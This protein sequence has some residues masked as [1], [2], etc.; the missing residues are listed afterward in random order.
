MDKKPSRKVRVGRVVSSATEKTAVVIVEEL[1]R[2]P[3]YGKTVKKSTRLHAHDEKNE[4]SVGDLVRI[5]ETRPISRMKRWKLV[6][7]VEKAR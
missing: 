7:I 1:V 6:D 2:H 3:L 4:C 5:M